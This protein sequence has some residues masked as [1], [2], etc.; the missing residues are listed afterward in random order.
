MDP[1]PQPSLFEAICSA[2]LCE[3][4][5]EKALQTLALV[6]QW[7]N[8]GFAS[9]LLTQNLNQQ[10][11]SDRPGRPLLP[12]L[13]A[14]REMPRRG[15]GQAGRIALLHALAH[16]ELNAIDLAL[17]IIGRFFGDLPQ[18]D[19]DKIAF[20]HDWLSVAADEA[21][22]F[23][24]LENRLKALGSGYGALPAHDGLWEAA[25][26]T[27][28]DLLARLAIVPLSLEAR[29][30]DVTPDMIARMEGAGDVESAKILQ[31]IYSDEITHVRYGM[32][33]FLRLCPERGQAP[34]PAYQHYVAQFLHGGLKPPFNVEA[35]DLTGMPSAFYA[36][37]PGS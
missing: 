11:W 31:I 28:D 33:W 9:P 26:D 3:S 7:R 15:R 21:K 14:P 18:A 17:D 25:C 12:P 22:H 23:L 20:I 30:L 32:D 5:N 19:D 37:I 29:G 2:Y 16:I 27:G 1:L 35:R 34:A 10:P 6:R 8:D 24:M 4:A 13:R 36:S